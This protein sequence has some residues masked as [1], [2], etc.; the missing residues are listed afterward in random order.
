MNVGRALGS[1]SWLDQQLCAAISDY[2]DTVSGLFEVTA[3]G[4]LRSAKGKLVERLARRLVKIAWRWADRDDD[5]LEFRSGKHRVPINREYVNEI[6]NPVVKQHVI[7]NIDSYTYGLGCDVQ[8]YVN[9]E[10]KLAIECKA[11]S[12]AAMLKRIMV[13]A[14]LLQSVYPELRFALF[15]LESQLGGDYS[16]LTHPPLGSPSAHTIMSQFGV[17]VSV[18]VITLLHGERHVKRPIHRR[19]YY[20][21]LQLSG[22]RNALDQLSDLLAD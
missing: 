15:Q 9:D 14:S 8:C 1:A 17:D 5:A 16:D 7:D 10:F 3:G 19:E 6:Q 12:E 21:E 13:D 22:L 2:E 11:Y 20:K 18:S 4:T